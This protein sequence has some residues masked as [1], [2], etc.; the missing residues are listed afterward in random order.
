MD[1]TGIHALVERARS[2]DEDAWRDLHARLQPMLY[3]MAQR[4][5]GPDW[6]EQSVSDLMQETW[7]RATKGIQGFRGGSTDDETAAL[8]RAWLSRLVKN[9]RSN[10]KRAANAQRRKRP[11]GMQALRINGGEDSW[12]PGGADPPAHASTPSLNLRQEER[13]Q[14]IQ[15]ALEIL[16]DPKDR[17]VIQLRFFE[18]LSLAQ[19]AKRLGMTYDD[20]RGRFHRSLRLLEPRL[21]DLE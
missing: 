21:R 17:E 13:R 1:S 10:E 14:A 5:L 16:A 3:R 2:G 7:L 6:P 11:A 12:M 19:I 18:E 20:A 15:R 8:F 4:A 9:E